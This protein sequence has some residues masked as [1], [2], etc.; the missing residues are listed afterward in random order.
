MDMVYV[1]VKCYAY[2]NFVSSKLVLTCIY[3][4]KLEYIIYLK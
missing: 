1:M 2:I 3:E 4:I